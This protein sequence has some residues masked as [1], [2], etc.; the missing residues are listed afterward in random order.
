MLTNKLLIYMRN[1]FVLMKLL[2]Y[3]QQI[4][5]D[6]YEVCLLVAGGDDGDGGRVCWFRCSLQQQD[7]YILKFCFD[8]NN[9]NNITSVTQTPRRRLIYSLSFPSISYSPVSLFLLLW[10]GLAVWC[11]GN[12]LVSINAVAL[13]RARLVLGWVTAFGQVNCLIT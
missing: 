12:A 11:S 8:Y 3:L 7:W 2:W 9:N 1:F 5:P 4:R 13:H 10:I 6:Q